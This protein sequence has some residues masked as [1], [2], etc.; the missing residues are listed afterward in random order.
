MIGVDVAKFGIR[1]YRAR[2]RDVSPQMRGGYGVGL[3]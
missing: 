1:V 2:A 3:A